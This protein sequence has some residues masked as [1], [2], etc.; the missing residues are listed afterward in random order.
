MARIVIADA[1]P[2]IALARIGQ[3]ELLP[4]LFGEVSITSQ[5]ASEL[6]DGG[7]FPDSPALAA[8]LSQTWLKTIDLTQGLASG[9][10]ADPLALC[11][12][13]MNLH[14]IDLG[15]ASALVYAARCNLQGDLA[16]LVIDDFRGRAAA[17]H[18]RVAI[19]GTAGLLL[20]AKQ[21]GRVQAVKPLLMALRQSGYFLSDRLMDAALLSAAELGAAD[22][23]GGQASD[24]G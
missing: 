17:T 6:V 23:F 11:R 8:A 2:L 20:L 4:A 19:I 5:I 1:G 22:A 21:T 14:Q 16:L 7:P 10:A 13:L 9:Q 12:D 15:E 3:L 18:E 24:S